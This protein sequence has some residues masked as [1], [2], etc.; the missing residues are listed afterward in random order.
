MK[1]EPPPMFSQPQAEHEWLAPLEGDWTVES[2]CVMGPDQ[3]P[4]KT[5]GKVQGRTLGGLWILL[6]TEGDNPEG[7]KWRSVMTVGYDPVAQKY[8]GSFVGSMMANLWVYE[9]TLD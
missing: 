4:M 2:E 1:K 9:G 3:P 8:V 5:T 6:E 7:G